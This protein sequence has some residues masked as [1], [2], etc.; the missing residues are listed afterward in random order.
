MRKEAKHLLDLSPLNLGG[1]TIN[2][3]S[4]NSEPDVLVADA[5]SRCWHTLIN[6]LVGASTGYAVSKAVAVLYM[7]SKG[8]CENSFVVS[9]VDLCFLFFFLQYHQGKPSTNRREYT[10]CCSEGHILMS[11]IRPCCTFAS[12][13]STLAESTG[14]GLHTNC[15]F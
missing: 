2:P 7:S 11:E 12:R 6:S 14:G 9:R 8:T 4:V 3:S 1:A 15:T 13:Q 5:T 10:Q